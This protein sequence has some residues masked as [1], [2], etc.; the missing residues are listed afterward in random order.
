MSRVRVL[1]D[2]YH[3]RVPAG[4]VYAGRAAPGLRAS[5]YANRHRIGQCRAC[6]AVH[7]RAGALLG[8]AHDL[9]AR[10]DV[11]A[12]A[13]AELAGVDVAC[14]CPLDEPCHVDVLLRVVAGADPLEA[15]VD[16]LG[17]AEAGELAARL[18]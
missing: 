2:L 6:P 13:R 11:V 12:A 4:A 8:Y 16:V 17:V 9:A 1:G 5:Q 10:A 3:G 7:G 15:A 14:W 18:F